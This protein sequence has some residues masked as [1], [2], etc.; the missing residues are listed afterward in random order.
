MVHTPASHPFPAD[1]PSKCGF[2]GCYHSAIKIE[3]PDGKIEC[4]CGFLRHQK[5]ILVIPSRSRQTYS[6]RICLWDLAQSVSIVFIIQIV[7][8]I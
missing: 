7:W 8:T 5:H 4:S 3:I 2:E 1:K 6:K